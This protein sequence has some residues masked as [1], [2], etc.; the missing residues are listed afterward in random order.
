M[1]AFAVGNDGIDELRP[2]LPFASGE[3]F[4][5]SIRVLGFN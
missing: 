2:Y 4:N 1:G 3:P 5:I